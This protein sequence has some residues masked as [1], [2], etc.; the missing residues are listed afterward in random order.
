MRKRRNQHRQL[1]GPALLRCHARSNASLPSKTMARRNHGALHPSQN[2][3][4]QRIDGYRSRK[5]G[6]KQPGLLDLQRIGFRVGRTIIE[7]I[8]RHHAPPD[9]PA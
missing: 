3:R 6:I 1:S 7:K 5:R 2:Q 4:Q 8:V 9:L